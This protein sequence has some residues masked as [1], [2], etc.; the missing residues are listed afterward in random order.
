MPK[1]YAVVFADSAAKM[2]ADIST[3]GATIVPMANRAYSAALSSRADWKPGPGA[4]KGKFEIQRKKRIKR[5]LADKTATAGDRIVARLNAASKRDWD[6]IEIVPAEKYDF[7]VNVEPGDAAN[8]ATNPADFSDGFEESMTN[9]IISNEEDAIAAILADPAVVKVSLGDKSAVDLD[10]LGEAIFN[11]LALKETD[12]SQLVDDYIHM[13]SSTMHVSKFAAKALRAFKGTMFNVDSSQYADDIVPNFSYTN[14]EP[15][16]VNSHFDKFTVDQ[17][18][19]GGVADE[20]IVAIV[21]KDDAYFDSGYANNMHVLNTK[22][23]D[24][25]FNGHSYWGAGAVIDQKRIVVI[26]A[27]TKTAIVKKVNAA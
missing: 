20:K 5:K 22:L 14:A 27:K 18:G 17:S 24:E 19:N 13:S 7:L 9:A 26:T 8:F 23:L 15:G 2:Y 21:M 11:E 6:T 10:D 3:T 12:V 16:L 25:D 1:K 4:N